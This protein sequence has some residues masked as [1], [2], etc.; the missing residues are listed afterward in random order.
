[1]MNTYFVTQTY[2]VMEFDT[3]VIVTSSG[4]EV[5][6]DRFLD[7]MTEMRIN[8]VY[9]SIFNSA[10]EFQLPFFF[11]SVYILKRGR[12]ESS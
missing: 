8:Y 3:L 5:R 4:M 1:M 2:N 10:A 6:K 9:E 11:K 7:L 12:E